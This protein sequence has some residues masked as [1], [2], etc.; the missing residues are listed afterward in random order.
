M[1][2][3][4]IT[5]DEAR[6]IVLAAARPLAAEPVPVTEALDRVL[7]EDIHAAG[8]VPPFP[9]SAM[10]G[11][12]V[13]A[14]AGGTELS[15][16]GE[17]RAGTP[18]SRAPARGEA[19]RI[20][21]GGAVPAGAEAVIRQEDIE[22]A[23]DGMIRTLVG[24]PVGDNVRPAGDV[25]ERGAT[26]LERGALLGPAELAAVISAGAAEVMAGRRPRVKV[27][28]TG[29]ELRAPGEELGPGQIH[30]SNGAMLA[31]LALHAGGIPQESAVLPDSPEATEQGLSGALDQADVVIVAVRL[32][33]PAELS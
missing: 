29:D 22:D 31:G 24:V 15:V 3:R 28:S 14:V 6:D 7:A 17:S 13:H 30:N 2:Q 23:G 1:T 32:L 16:V 4:L 5:I 9:S 21:T 18:A 27:L 11:Y 20:S 12:A 33:K 8:D 10:D 19:I 26:V 25:M